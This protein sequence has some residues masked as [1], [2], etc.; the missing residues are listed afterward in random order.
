MGFACAVGTIGKGRRLAERCSGRLSAR[1]RV[2]T[3]EVLATTGKGA[4]C[5]RLQFR[6]CRQ[7]PLAS[8]PAVAEREPAPHS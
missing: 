2:C 1:A 5:A 3:T 8:G 7:T 4:E 6:L